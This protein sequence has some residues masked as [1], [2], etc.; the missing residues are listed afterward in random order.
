MDKSPLVSIRIP[1]YNH[2]KFVTKTLD[3]ILDD[4][5]PNKEIIIID[6][7]SND[8]TW[9]KILEWEKK[10]S[11]KIKIIAEKNAKNIGV[12]K[13]VNKLH[14]LCSGEYII[15][16]ASDD[17][18]I[19]G[20]IESRLHYLQ[21]NT[22]KKVVFGDC[23]VIDENDNL[24]FESG[25]SDLYSVNKANLF[26][27]NKMKKELILNWGVPGGTLM[28]KKEIVEEIQ[29][30]E[31]LIIEDFDL[32]LK[33]MAKDYLG[34]I[35]IKISKYRIHSSNAINNKEQQKRRYKDFLMTIT[36]NL[37]YF[38]LQYKLILLYAI[39]IRI[40]QRLKK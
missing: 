4:P 39:L 20:S 29:F 35:D 23:Q 16:I 9:E 32:F 15:G 26:D 28:V 36:S 33:W 31:K 2:E 40:I 3:S 21:T 27:N 7:C 37:K 8:N 25:L 12:S 10:H 11:D 5:Y 24:L 1:A 19:P 30:N 18:L 17:I 6:D 14:S 13:T 34:F 38:D 22:D